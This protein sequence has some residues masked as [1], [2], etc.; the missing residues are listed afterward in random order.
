MRAVSPEAI[1]ILELWNYSEIRHRL[2]KVKTL[3]RGKEQR[4]SVLNYLNVFSHIIIKKA[5]FICLRN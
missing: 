4:F 2:G 1:K 3:Q 5:Y